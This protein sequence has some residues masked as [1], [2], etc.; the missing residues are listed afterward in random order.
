MSHKATSAAAAEPPRGARGVLRTLITGGIERAGGIAVCSDGTLAATD[1]EANVVL[2]VMVPAIAAAGAGGGAAIAV[3][4]AGVRGQQGNAD[5]AGEFARFLRPCGI[6]AARDGT[7]VVADQLNH[8]LR[9]LAPD[10]TVTTLAGSGARGSADG[11]AAAAQFKN[12]GDVALRCDGTVVVADWFNHAVRVVAPPDDDAGAAAAA[13][14]VTTVAGAQAQAGSSTRMR[15]RRC[16][17]AAAWS[18]TPVTTGLSRCQRPAAPSRWSQARAR[19]R[20]P[21]A[22]ARR[23]RLRPRPRWPSTSTALQWSPT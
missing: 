5:G 17:T 1:A 16:P 18:A 22:S 3:V 23:R 12:P 2:R 20:A 13:A 14:A 9:A 8:R 4:V 10:S 15:S 19:K 11:P 21:T 6:A 7:L